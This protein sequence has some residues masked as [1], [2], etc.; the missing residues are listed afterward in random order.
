MSNFEASKLPA[1]A[2]ADSATSEKPANIT[3]AN[4]AEADA[5]PTKLSDPLSVTYKIE[6]AKDYKEKGNAFFKAGE[7]KKV[8]MKFVFGCVYSSNLRQSSCVW[9]HLHFRQSHST[10]E[11]L[12]IQRA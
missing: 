11:C 4:G 9:P 1:D 8:C 10:V 12:R 3:L 2:S 5:S 6:K 7:F